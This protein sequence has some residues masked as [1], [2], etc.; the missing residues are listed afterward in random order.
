M[1]KSHSRCLRLKELA[2][3]ER[4]SHQDATSTAIATHLMAPELTKRHG[5]VLILN[6]EASPIP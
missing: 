5:Q 3:T 6:F 2:R 1:V 4:Q